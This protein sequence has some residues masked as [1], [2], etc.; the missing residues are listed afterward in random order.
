MHVNRANGLP[1][2]VVY[3]VMPDKEGALWLALD[4]GLARVEV[5]SPASFFDAD[6]G[7]PGPPFDMIRLQGRLYAAG[8]TG[9][10]YLDPPAPGAGT[11]RFVPVGGN[12]SQCW[13]FT[14]MPDAPARPGLRC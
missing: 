2:D 7:L 4:S 14:P 11:P 10:L 13:W 3:F 12:R 5:P 6:D 8:Q 9:V 1:S